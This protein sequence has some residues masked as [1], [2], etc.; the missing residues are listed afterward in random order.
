MCFISRSPFFP[1]RTSSTYHTIAWSPEAWQSVPNPRW[2]QTSLF[3]FLEC[4]RSELDKACM[5]VFGVSLSTSPVLYLLR[6]NSW[7]NQLGRGRVDFN[8]QSGE[9]HHGEEGMAVR[10]RGSRSHS[11]H[12]QEA[13]TD[14]CCYSAHSLLFSPSWSL[15]APRTVLLGWVFPPQLAHSRNFLT[16]RLRGLSLVMLDPMKLKLYR[17]HMI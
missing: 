15:A 10:D 3:H 5:H 2:L 6:P 11:I 13:E 4:W 1:V 7:R 17:A 14:K 12:G 9:V 8:S 16:D